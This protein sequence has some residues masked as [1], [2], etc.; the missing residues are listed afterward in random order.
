MP[1]RPFE[2]RHAQAFFHPANLPRDRT[3]SQARL[4][5]SLRETAGLHHEMEQAQ[6]IKIE[7]QCGEKFIHFGNQYNW[8]NE[9]HAI[10]T[11]L[12]SVLEHGI[13]PE[14]SASIPQ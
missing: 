11:L 3:L 1:R 6:L 13:E 8:N 10:P 4:L 9:F 2:Q 5:S 14:R 12:H 7:G